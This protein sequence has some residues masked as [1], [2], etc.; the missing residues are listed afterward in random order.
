Q[1]LVPQDVAGMSEAMGGREQTLARLDRFFA[2]DTIAADPNSARAEWVA[3]PY[4]YYGQHRYNPNNEPTMHTPWIYTL[5][6]RPDRTAAVV[7]AAQ[8]LFTNAPN[9]VTGNDDL[10]TMSAWY[11][12]GAMGLYPGMPGTGQMLVGTP[13]FEQVEIDLGQ[14]RILRIHAPGA[15]GERVQYVSGARLN[16]QAFDR[17]WLDWDQL[18]TGGRI[19][20]R[21][22]DRA[23]RAHWGQGEEATPRGVCRAV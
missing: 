8:T 2:F 21:L 18:K 13:R 7:R 20:L 5:L 1:W 14:G 12:F 23:D 9:G 16:G 11:L 17:V 22:T 4:A 10:G 19:D 15:A 3:G 6:G